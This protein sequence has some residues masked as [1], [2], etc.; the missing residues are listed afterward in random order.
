MQDLSLGSL[1][2]NFLNYERR[3]SLHFPTEELRAAWSSLPTSAVGLADVGNALMT[4]QPAPAADLLR[5][6]EHALKTSLA[7]DALA[8]RRRLHIRI[9]TLLEDADAG[10]PRTQAPL[11]RG[12]DVPENDAS[13]RKRR[14][15]KTVPFTARLCLLDPE[16]ISARVT[17]P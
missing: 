8:C 4:G 12:I 13:M 10:V 2:D 9:L 5:S 16:F 7:S 3:Q 14:L 1:L 6:I 15:N 11:K 17:S